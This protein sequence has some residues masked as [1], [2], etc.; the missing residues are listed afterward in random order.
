MT[1]FIR[2]AR[3][4]QADIHPRMQDLFTS[5][6]GGQS[7][8]TLFI[9]CS[10]S[11]IDPALITQTEPGSLFVIRNAGNIIP[12]PETDRGGVSAA[13]ELAIAVLKVK[14]IVICGHSGCGAMEA[15]I[16]EGTLAALPFVR[17]WVCKAEAAKDI[18]SD[19]GNGE[20]SAPRLIQLVRANVI[21][22][23]ERIWTHPT[24]AP[25]KKTGGVRVHGWVYDIG[26]GVID[27]FDE[28]SGTFVTFDRKYDKD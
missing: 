21:L 27:V 10:D 28:K 24:L 20:S 11:R 15:L 2:G 1:D 3:K 19:E 23:M 16:D 7:P 26:S 9:T 12:T 25:L 8:E 18:N 6:E 5:L 22:Q 14:D 4:F 17:D 13:I